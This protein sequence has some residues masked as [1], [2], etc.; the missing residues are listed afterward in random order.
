MFFRRCVIKI[1]DNYVFRKF[2]L[3]YAISYFKCGGTTFYGEGG[4]N[5]EA[6]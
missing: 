2:T 4:T 3:L 6:Y 1:D 5:K